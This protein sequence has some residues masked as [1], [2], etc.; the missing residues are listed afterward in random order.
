[1]PLAVGWFV[2]G[3]LLGV[4]YLFALIAAKGLVIAKVAY[5]RRRLDLETI[6]L[7]G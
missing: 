2:W 5:A 4:L 1:M 3:G 7:S 6:S